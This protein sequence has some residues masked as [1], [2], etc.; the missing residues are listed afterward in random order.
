MA[1]GRP[2]GFDADAALD[3]AV[4]VF[5]QKGYEGASLSDLTEA[6]GINR[7]SLY[8][9]FGD[10]ET[11]F[12]KALD[13]YL[14]GAMTAPMEALEE[15]ADTRMAVCA[16]LRLLAHSLT[17]P[18]HPPGCLVVHG[19]LS[20]SAEAAPAA[21]ALLECR[22]SG[23]A[24][25]RARLERGLAAGDLPAGTD[26]AALACFFATVMQGMAVQAKSGAGRDALLAV[27]DRAM[28]AWP[29]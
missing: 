20:C 7:P 16:W 24:R 25:V 26:V 28:A 15:I 29:A 27:V 21:G 8:A 19:A 5:W 1:R 6:M 3:K 11:L 12:R 22:Q 9:A 10:K 14:A 17:D 2:R 18:A 4:R 23:E 13:R